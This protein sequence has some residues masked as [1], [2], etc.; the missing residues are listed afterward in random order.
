MIQILLLAI[1]AFFFSGCGA[2]I[3]GPATHAATH[4]TWKPIGPAHCTVCGGAK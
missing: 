4:S 2:S 1:A 3:P